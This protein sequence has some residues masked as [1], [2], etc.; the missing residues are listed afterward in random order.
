MLEVIGWIGSI[1]FSL[2]ALPQAL[3]CLRQ[4]HA[5]GCDAGFLLLWFIGEVASLIYI[6]PQDVLPVLFNYIVNLLFLV[7]ILRYKFWERR[8]PYELR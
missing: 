7:V 3:L 6:I 5:R 8:D 2:C 4:G 1:C